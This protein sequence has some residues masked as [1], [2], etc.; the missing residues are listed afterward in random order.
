MIYFTPILA[1]SFDVR[2]IFCFPSSFK[3]LKPNRECKRK[4]SPS[5]G[6]MISTLRKTS[7]GMVLNGAGFRILIAFPSEAILNI[8]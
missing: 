6:I 1:R 2:I 8:S 4:S 3:L 7:I 5:L